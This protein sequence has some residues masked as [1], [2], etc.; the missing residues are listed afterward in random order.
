MAIACFA[1]DSRWGGFLGKVGFE[2]WEGYRTS[3]SLCRPWYP[4][5]S[6]VM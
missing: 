4:S 2:P 5:A 6:T 1:R 3:V